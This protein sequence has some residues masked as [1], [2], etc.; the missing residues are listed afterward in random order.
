MPITYCA[1]A[2]L[3]SVAAAL[4][5]SF[6]CSRPG[7]KDGMFSAAL[8]IIVFRIVKSMIVECGWGF[9]AVAGTTNG[10]V[11]ESLLTLCGLFFFSEVAE[12]G[13]RMKKAEV[14]HRLLSVTGVTL[15]CAGKGMLFDGRL[16]SDAAAFIAGKAA[17]IALL[18]WAV[19]L[20]E[21]ESARDV[22]RAPSLWAAVCPVGSFVLECS[23]RPLS[24]SGE[25]ASAPLL[26]LFGSCALLCRLPERMAAWQKPSSA[27]L[28]TGLLLSYAFDCLTG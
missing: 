2:C 11:L 27:G 4:L 28:A 23:V 25:V 7:R 24:G 14:S 10:L 5:L 1:A 22:W 15:I 21:E 13:K 8:G 20:T 3:V 6:A 18:S 19:F 16:I 9:A 17:G 12:S 26:I